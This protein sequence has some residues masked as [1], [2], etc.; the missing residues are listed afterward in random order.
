MT[1]ETKKTTL[2][3]AQAHLKFCRNFFGQIVGKSDNFDGA[4]TAAEEINSRHLKQVYK[5]YSEVHT[6]K[7]TTPAPP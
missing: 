1:S 5:L 6:H 4:H 3:W 2:H 7:Y